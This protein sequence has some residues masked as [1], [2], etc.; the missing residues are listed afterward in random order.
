[1]S[2]LLLHQ[3]MVEQSYLDSRK[4]ILLERLN[5]QRALQKKICDLQQAYQTD[6][7]AIRTKLENE[8]QRLRESLNK[9]RQDVELPTLNF[10]F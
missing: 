10:K 9:W 3:Y 6:S 8:T 2:E 7:E 4:A 5:E 1:M